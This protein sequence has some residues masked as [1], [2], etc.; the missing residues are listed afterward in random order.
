MTLTTYVN[1]KGTCAE[2][3]QFYAE[4]LGGKV[5]MLIRHGQSPVAGNVAPDWQDKVLN[6]S[7]QIGGTTLMGADVPNAEPMRSA[8]LTATFDTVADAQQAYD[9]L[10]AEGEVFM[11]LR[12]EFFAEAFAMLRDRFG[13][14]WMILGGMRQS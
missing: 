7:L 3:S 12:P 1:F 4:H 9:A 5:L 13:V 11:P 6:A 10:S 2:A 14:N 8:Y